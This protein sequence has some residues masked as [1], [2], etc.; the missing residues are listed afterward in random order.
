MPTTL[1]EHIDQYK[2]RW[3]NA[4]KKYANTYPDKKV[5][6]NATQNDR[7]Y[8]SI[9]QVANELLL[10]NSNLKG[11]IA[12]SKNYI[13]EADKQI[14]KV[15]KDH[16]EQKIELVSAIGSNKAAKPFKIDKYD[17]NSESYISIVAYIIAICSTSFFIYKQIKQ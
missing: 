7:A 6:G 12:N 13:N 8:Q 14:K 3:N 16:E 15:K 11:D 9:I 4:T 1:K 2:F 5:N 10:F 17:E